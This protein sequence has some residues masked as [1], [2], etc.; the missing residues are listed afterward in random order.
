[1]FKK[2]FLATAILFGSPAGLLN[3]QTAVAQTQQ[4]NDGWES[5]G[6]VTASLYNKRPIE[7]IVGELFVKVIADKVIYQFRYRGERYSVTTYK[8]H[9]YATRDDRG[10]IKF[11]GNTYVF[12]VPC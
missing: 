6:K 4:T 9:D 11:D 1:M 2:V 3:N 8:S 7:Y 5:L 10:Y 12:D